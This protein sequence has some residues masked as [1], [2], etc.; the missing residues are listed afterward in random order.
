MYRHGHKKDEVTEMTSSEFRALL[1]T[2]LNKL[3]NRDTVKNG[4][5]ELIGIIRDLSVDDDSLSIFMVSILP[6]KH[7]RINMSQNSML[8]GSESAISAYKKEILRIVA[9]CASVHHENLSPFLTRILSTIAK[10][11]K[12]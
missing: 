7:P 3:N 8:E 9:S 2:S 5:D 11:L 12:V 6:M 1:H 10:Y 4:F